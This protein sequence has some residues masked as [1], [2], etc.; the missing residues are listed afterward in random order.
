MKNISKII[1]STMLVATMSSCHIY[2]KY[3]LPKDNA[4]IGEYQ[5][6]LEAPVDSAMLGNLAWNEVF[7]DTILQ[8]Y[9]NQAL[10]VNKDYKNAKLNIDIAHAQLKGAKLSYLPSLT[11]TPNGGAASYAGSPMSLTYSLPLAASWEIDI[12]GKLLN[13]K[14]KAQANLEQTEAYTQ[15]VRSQII[16]AVANTYYTLVMLNQQLEITKSTASLWEEQVESM[17][18]MKEAGRV[19]EAAVVQSRANYYY[20]LSTIPDIE[21][22]IHQTNNTLSLLLNTHY[23]KW[24][25]AQTTEFKTPELLNDGIPVGYLSARP[26]VKAAEKSFASAFYAT[27]IARTN[28]YPSLVISAQGGFT[29]LLGSVIK[30]PGEWFVQLAGSLTAPI[31]SRGKNIATLEAAKAQQKQALNNFEY[32]VLNASAE[33]SNALVEISN[34]DAKRQMLILQVGQLEKSVEYTQEL[35]YLGQATY[36]EVLSAQESLLSAQLSSLNCWHA[37]VSAMIN[38]YQALGGGR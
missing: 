11:F 17:V 29:N 7:T 21:N 8:R 6:S 12:F 30:N 22:T 10:E 16:G 4:I 32:T 24:D 35:L 37:K 33:V 14:R 38:L 34:N 1:L 25:V 20:I 26:D 27:N 9:I 15:A 2:N 18:L 5:K 28:F 3:E 36:L 13:N 23:Q 31:F 19:N